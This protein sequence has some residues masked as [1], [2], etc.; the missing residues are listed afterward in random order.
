MNQGQKTQ[1]RNIADISCS[2]KRIDKE[3]EEISS[4]QASIKQT[5]IT[6]TCRLHCL[7]SAINTIS[8]DIIYNT[9]TNTSSVPNLAA[10]RRSNLEHLAW[11]FRKL[12][13]DQIQT[14]KEVEETLKKD[15][16][17]HRRYQALQVC[18][19]KVMEDLA[20]I[21]REVFSD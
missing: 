12:R 18:I 3:I 1:P 11:R 17:L 9:N 16:E 5:S 20:I 19:R 4:K 6:F 14:N 15:R 7:N 10:Q 21:V 2:H 13:L 8:D